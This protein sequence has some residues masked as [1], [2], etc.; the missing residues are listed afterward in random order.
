MF[1]LK[2]RRREIYGDKASDDSGDK[3]ITIR[4]VGGLP[5]A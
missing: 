5:D 2:G 4:V 1:M 3:S